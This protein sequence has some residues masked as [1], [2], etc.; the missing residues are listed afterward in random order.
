MGT[1]GVGGNEKSE[2]VLSEEGQLGVKGVG[3][4]GLKNSH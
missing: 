2:G 4:E 3:I 1:E